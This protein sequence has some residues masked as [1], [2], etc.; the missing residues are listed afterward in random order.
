MRE[1]VSYICS[2]CGG[3]LTVEKTSEVL[4]CPFCG[5][6]YDKVSLLR[7]ELLS[8]ASASMKVMEFNAAKDRYK[9]ILESNPNDYE[10]L[11]GTILCDG[12]IKS[13]ET[14]KSAQKM[15]VA[16]IE[17]MKKTAEEL[18]A[19]A[20]EN[21]KPCLGKIC[22]LVSLAGEHREA[23]KA[24]EEFTKRSGDSFGQIVNVDIK[25]EESRKT[26]IDIF[27]L[28]GLLIASPLLGADSTAE[29]RES[30]SYMGMIVIILIPA[31][32]IGYF[33]GLWSILIFFG[34][35]LAIF[36]ISILI[37]RADEKKKAPIR[38]QMA[39]I[40]KEEAA[41]SAKIAQVEKQYTDSYNELIKLEMQLRK[42]E[43]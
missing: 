27:K 38:E 40:H 36:G 4:N 18:L 2:Q 1:L 43:E 42:K 9:R 35:I 39:K 6:A 23:V 11:K 16:D 25:R 30:A 8:D 31:C 24:K 33:F 14:L 15:K 19:A 21:T 7:D 12:G 37:K 13:A 29:D 41:L 34:I 26:A 17:N 22:E 28:L 20:D 3:A 5:N 32:L 10:A